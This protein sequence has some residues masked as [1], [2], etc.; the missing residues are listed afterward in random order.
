LVAWEEEVEPMTHLRLVTIPA[1]W[2]YVR[3]RLVCDDHEIVAME[4]GKSN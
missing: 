2:S 3:G 4:D 1:T